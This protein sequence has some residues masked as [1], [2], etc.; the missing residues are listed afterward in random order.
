L[1]FHYFHYQYEHQTGD[2]KADSRVDVK[3]SQLQSFW[4]NGGPPE[5]EKFGIKSSLRQKQK[6]ISF[7]E[8]LFERL[9]QK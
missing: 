9:K 4:Q 7:S 6:N 5:K 1:I 2:S 8:K 3:S